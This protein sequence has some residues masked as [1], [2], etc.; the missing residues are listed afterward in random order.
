MC[1]SSEGR[2]SPK[3]VLQ[4]LVGRFPQCKCYT[5]AGQ[6]VVE[7]AVF[8]NAVITAQPGRGEVSTMQVLQ[9]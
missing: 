6:R 4:I 9:F 2:A 8:P 7:L 5:F 1:Y 3:E